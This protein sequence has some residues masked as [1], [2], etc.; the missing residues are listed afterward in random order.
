MNNQNFEV[1]DDENKKIPNSLEECKKPSKLVLSLRNYA[2]SIASLGKILSIVLAVC[3]FFEALFTSFIYDY[4]GE[5]ESF[6]TLNFFI[7]LVDT[8]IYIIIVSSLCTFISVLI[9]AVANLVYN[10]NISVNVALYNANKSEE[11]FQEQNSSK[12]E[13]EVSDENKEI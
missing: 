3:G 9:Y 6:S 10:N 11:A 8:F 5:L 2:S 4:D 7:T 13:N 12:S 1:K